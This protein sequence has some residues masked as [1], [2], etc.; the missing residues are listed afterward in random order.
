MFGRKKNEKMN[1]TV[2]TLKM[3][4]YF[5]SEKVSKT[6]NLSQK[7]TVLKEEYKQNRNIDLFS[8]NEKEKIIKPLSTMHNINSKITQIESN[9]I[10]DDVKS[11]IINESNYK[12]SVIPEKIVKR[13]T[14]SNNK[15]QIKKNE[16]ASSKISKFF[17]K[18]K[19]ANLL[20][21]EIE[22]TSNTNNT[23]SNQ[24]VISK[25]NSDQYI[26]SIKNLNFIAFERKLDKSKTMFIGENSNSRLSNKNDSEY[27]RNLS[28][29]NES[30]FHSIKNSSNIKILNDNDQGSDFLRHSKKYK[31][32]EIPPNFDNIL[33]HISN[34]QG[35]FSQ[36]LCRKRNRYNSMEKINNAGED[37][38]ERP[39]NLN[40]Y[41][42]QK[43]F[44]DS[45]NQNSNSILE[46]NSD[47][48]NYNS[49]KIQFKEKDYKNCESILET[50]DFL[51][52]NHDNEIR[53]LSEEG[54]F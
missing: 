51:N 48:E 2:N 43:A 35:H 19:R 20:G 16:K 8:S 28:T 31:M 29:L 30:S 21:D 50:N 32:K 18:V 5:P 25:M 34:N 6:L 9:A 7:M 12:F 11:T 49:L 33:S 1:D 53:F 37:D 10:G 15:S 41:E 13:N 14:Q 47:N 39:I 40:H 54:K 4:H 24:E 27:D 45:F 17:V 46:Y 38:E 42:M 52:D 3:E 22:Y 36:K 23:N 44:M 26:N